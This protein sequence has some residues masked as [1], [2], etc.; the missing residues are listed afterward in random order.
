[1]ANSKT[2][3]TE[4][5]TRGRNSLVRGIM[6]A[7]L[8]V[9]FFLVIVLICM[10][11]CS[12]N[13]NT[14]LNTH[15]SA[16][17]IAGLVVSF[18][19]FLGIFYRVVA[20]QLTYCSER[21]LGLL[22]RVIPGL[23]ILLQCVFLLYF[24]SAYL[25]DSAFVAGAASSLARSGEV[26]QEAWYYMSVYPNQNAF[27]VFTALVWKLCDAVGMQAGNI[28]LVLN[29]INM[30]CIDISQ[31]L[32]LLT[33]KEYRPHLSKE[34]WVVILLFICMN[35]FLY[36]GVSYYYTI[37]LS[38]PFFMFVLYG[39]S[40]L[41]CD[42]GKQTSS[43]M[44]LY[45]ALGFSFAI[46]YLF[47]ATTI[48]ALIAGVFCMY[49]FRKWK[50]KH[51]VVLLTVIATLWIGSSV[52]EKVVGIDTTD[53]AF[54]ATHWLMMSM[55]APGSHNAEDEQFTS[56][57]G[58]QQEKK[59]AVLDR[60]KEKAQG[61]GVKGFAHLAIAKLRNTW[62]DG[63]N[64]YPVFLEHCL[65][66][67]TGYEAIFGRHN[68]AV[69]LY[70]QAYWLLVLLGIGNAVFW[71]LKTGTRERYLFEVT[72]LGAILF[73]LLWETGPQYSLPFW[74]V[75]SFLA[76]AGMERRTSEEINGLYGLKLKR[77]E[78]KNCK[79]NVLFVMAI[80][81]ILFV[82]IF[83]IKKIEV[84]TQSQGEF[85]HPVVSQYL[86]NYEL[87]VS[88]EE[89]LVQRF[90]TDQ[91]FNRILFQYRN[92][93]ADSDAVY[94]VEVIGEKQGRVAEDE[95]VAA[96]QPYNSAKM[97]ETSLIYPVGKEEFRI[98][99]WKKAGSREK[100]LRFVTYR[101]GEYDAYPVGKL[102][103]GEQE[104]KQDL[105]FAV[106]HTYAGAYTSSKR[107][108]VFAFVTVLVYTITTLCLMEIR[109]CKKSQ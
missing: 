90:T 81:C 8:F 21:F 64:G 55:T 10:A 53:T 108:A 44:V 59:E 87:T 109:T 105:L 12:L 66:T 38:M 37:T 63:T 97:I 15:V 51:M 106:T 39:C 42:R 74:P 93:D 68:D 11:T 107:Y 34:K 25:F 88:G 52:G 5:E 58:T 75:L 26:A 47:R 54:P 30:M 84:F 41:L 76:L 20:K 94:G 82:S 50:P 104:E 35:P 99:I 79:V 48:I 72:L 24:K 102:I 14:F 49:A 65:N 2:R 17:V 29:A 31:F 100:N 22:L 45:T 92:E 96:G 78:T 23:A 86:A 7:S 89:E 33:I 13:E 18:T 69:V 4:N 101:M 43:S 67:K 71:S 98:R 70:H 85:V 57:F 60:M 46:G 73:Y 56:S 80:F 28:P 9:L 1:M 3:G 16:P 95:L 6:T 19:V 27:A 77:K 32:L 83:F 91:P 36:I 62:A 61:L 103:L 40:R